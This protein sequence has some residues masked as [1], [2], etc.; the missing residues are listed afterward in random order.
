[1]NHVALLMCVA[2]GGYHPLVSYQ[3]SRDGLDM[4][5]EVHPLLYTTMLGNYTCRVSS[6]QLEVSVEHQFEVKGM[7]MLIGLSMHVLNL[8]RAN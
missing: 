8:K 5:G 4:E 2:L 3:W 1:M 6:K 7:L